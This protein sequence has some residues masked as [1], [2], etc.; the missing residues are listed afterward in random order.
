M[1]TA[2]PYSTVNVTAETEEAQQ[3]HAAHTYTG[4]GRKRGEKR[5]REKKERKKGRE[6]RRLLGGTMC[7]YRLR[8]RVLE[9]CFSPN[10]IIER[11]FHPSTEPYSLIPLPAC[12]IY[13]ATCYK[14]SVLFANVWCGG[15]AWMCVGRREE[16]GALRLE[17]NTKSSPPPLP[18]TH[19]S[20]LIHKSWEAP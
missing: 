9:G 5:E 6:R 8:T 14:A 3:Q 19:F 7:S 4:I 1:S 13:D 20:P 10:T 12:P 2:P 11:S 17:A 15:A 18:H 16:V